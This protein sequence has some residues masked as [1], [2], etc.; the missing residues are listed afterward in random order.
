MT[1]EWSREVY[2]KDRVIYT[3][4]PISESNGLFQR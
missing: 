1:D 2:P 3:L 4:I